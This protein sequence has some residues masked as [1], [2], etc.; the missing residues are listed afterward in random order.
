MADEL[1][2][3]CKAEFKYRCPRRW[4]ELATKDDPK[5]R[6]CHV[7]EKDVFLSAT[8]DEAKANARLGRCVAIARSQPGKVELDALVID[9]AAER[10]LNRNVCEKYLLYP[11]ALKPG[12]L[13][14]AMSDPS[15]PFAL[16]EVRFLTGLNVE[17]VPA[18]HASLRAALATAYPPPRDM[19]VM[20]VQ[21]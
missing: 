1:V 19:G 21:D 12:T 13:V 5:V 20:L 2:D 11:V 6:Y 9:P 8:V 3:N 7:C 17:A 10:Y 4:A 15:D 18:S 14:V 16:D